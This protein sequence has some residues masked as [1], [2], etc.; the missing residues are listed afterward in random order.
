MRTWCEVKNFE[1]QKFRLTPDSKILE[2]KRSRSLKKWLRPPLGGRL[3][4]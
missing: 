4:L 3:Q 1:S 2:E